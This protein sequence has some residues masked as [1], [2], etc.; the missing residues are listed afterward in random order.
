MLHMYRQA[1]VEKT[2][3]D[4]L[5]RQLIQLTIKI[6]INKKYTFAT[7]RNCSQIDLGNHEYHVYLVEEIEFAPGF[8]KSSKK[9]TTVSIIYY[10][11]YVGIIYQKLMKN[12]CVFKKHTY[13][14]KL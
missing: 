4:G 14:E 7:R 1:I 13:L 12:N 6:E 10:L 9:H 2:L 11:K 3:Q 8:L 5:F